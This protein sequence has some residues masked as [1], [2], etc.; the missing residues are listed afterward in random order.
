[1]PINS[2]VHTDDRLTVAVTK[3]AIIKIDNSQQAT[4]VTEKEK[5]GRKKWVP[6]GSNNLLP[7]DIAEESRRNTIIPTILDRKARL[8]YSGGLQYGI[9]EYDETGEREIY[10]PQL[11]AKPEILKYLRKARYEKVVREAALNLV[12]YYRFYVEFIKSNDGKK[13]ARLKIHPVRE[14]RKAWPD[15]RTGKTKF[16]Y[17]NAN[18]KTDPNGLLAK[19][20]AFIDDDVY[21]PVEEIRKHKAKNIVMEFAMPSIDTKHY[22]LAPWDSIRQSNWLKLAEQIPAFKTALMKFQT[23]IK[24][25]VDVSIEYFLWKYPKYKEKSEKEQAAIRTKFLKDLDDNVVG[26]EKAG[27]MLMNLVHRTQ[28]GDPIPGLS[29]TAVDDKIKDG[30]YIEDSQEASNHTFIALDSDP[31]ASG[32]GQRAF[33]SGGGSDKGVAQNIALL[34]SRPFQDLIAEP[35]RMM[36][37]FNEWEDPENPLIWRFRLNFMQTESSR[38]QITK[39]EKNALN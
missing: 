12:W 24:Y 25:V 4:V 5:P 6:N 8:Y 21:D 7:Q 34:L 36:G 18:W 23:T 10:K 39:T 17:I 38:Q 19:E 33:G 37:E 29:I 3:D 13:I 9:L 20:V 26:P 30:I 15:K 16:I 31:V 2:V 28:Q 22:T 35:F 14:C 27:K 32:T 1:M 11:K